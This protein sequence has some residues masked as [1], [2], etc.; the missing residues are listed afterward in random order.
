MYVKVK[1][2][3]EESGKWKNGTGGIIWKTKGDGRQSANKPSFKMEEV[4]R[5]KSWLSVTRKM[6][7]KMSKF[8]RKSFCFFPFSFLFLFLGMC[9]YSCLWFWRFYYLISEG[10]ALREEG[11]GERFPL[12]LRPGFSTFI[13]I[14]LHVHVQC[15]CGISHTAKNYM[16]L[17]QSHIASFS[18]FLFNNRPV[19]FLIL[20]LI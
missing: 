19:W 9:F 3:V 12:P 20:I 5:G 4:G 8:Y 10:G 18:L 13:Y 16:G 15:A 14:L 17:S 6:Q 1:V 2:E 7:Q 11:S